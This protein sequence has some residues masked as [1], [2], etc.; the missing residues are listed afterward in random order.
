MSYDTVRLIAANA[1]G[2]QLQNRGNWGEIKSG[3]VIGKARRK[4]G[5]FGNETLAKGGNWKF[6]MRSWGVLETRGGKL[7]NPDVLDWE[8]TLIN[9]LVLGK[10]VGSQVSGLCPVC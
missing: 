2:R 8:F 5:D 6:G 1:T 7:E 4:A 3:V 10:I 9:K